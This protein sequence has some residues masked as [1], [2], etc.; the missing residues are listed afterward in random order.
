[1]D[2]YW[3]EK[4]LIGCRWCRLWAWSGGSSRELFFYSPKDFLTYTVEPLIARAG[5]VDRSWVLSKG[6]FRASVLASLFAISLFAIPGVVSATD[7]LQVSDYH[8]KVLV[9]DFWASWCVPCRRSFPWMNEMQQKYGDEDLVIVA[10]NLDNEASDAAEFLR[11]YPAKFKISYDPERN[12]AREFEVEA[13]PTSFLIDRN[14][15]VI[16]RHLGFKT[17][18]VDDYEAAIVSALRNKP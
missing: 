14:G 10:V 5:A 18:Q 2:R 6:S 3:L 4:R 17:G 11:Q 9:V 16:E 12:L 1:V 15:N 13:M 7:T 8:G